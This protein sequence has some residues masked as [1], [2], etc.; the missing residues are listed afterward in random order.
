MIILKWLEDYLNTPEIELD[1]ATQV[2]GIFALGLIAF[3]I[4][5]VIALILW[6]LHKYGEYH[7]K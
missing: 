5:N 4:I 1:L 6:L 2:L 7:G 3:V